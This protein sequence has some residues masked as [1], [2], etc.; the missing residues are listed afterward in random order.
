MGGVDNTD[1][2]ALINAGG[3][4][5]QIAFWEAARRFKIEKT[6][7]SSSNASYADEMRAEKLDENFAQLIIDYYKKHPKADVVIFNFKNLFLSLG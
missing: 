4:P 3:T 2:Q 5:E 1:Y 6:D 7:W